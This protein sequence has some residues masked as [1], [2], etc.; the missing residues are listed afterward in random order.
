MYRLFEFLTGKDVSLYRFT[1]IVTYDNRRKATH[2]H[3]WQPKYL[4]P[5]SPHLNPIERIWLTMRARG[6]NKYVCKNQQK[7]LEHLDQAILDG[8]DNPKN[9]RK[10]TD[11]GTLF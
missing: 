11:I 1:I 2:W 10:T 6:F 7:L 9:I 3:H 4:P 8:I 5:Y